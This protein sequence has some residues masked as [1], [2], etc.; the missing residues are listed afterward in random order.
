MKVLVSYKF[1]GVVPFGDGEYK[2]I[3]ELKILESFF[4]FFKREVK[5][6]YKISMSANRNEYHKLWDSL[7]ECKKPL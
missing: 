5:Y 6:N 7:I 1:L 3:Y 2:Y 4:G